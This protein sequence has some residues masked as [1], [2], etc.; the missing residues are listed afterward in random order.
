MA[1]S[2]GLGRKWKAKK[3]CSLVV[4]FEW[5][6][7]PYLCDEMEELL[8]LPGRRGWLEIIPRNIVYVARPLNFHYD[9]EL[10]LHLPLMWNYGIL[11]S[12]S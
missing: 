8:W 3:S 2:I 11:F 5:S 10:Y 4:L 7:L 6:F 9:K 1:H 12:Y